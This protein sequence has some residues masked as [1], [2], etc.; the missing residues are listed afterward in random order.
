M[1][2]DLT[3]FGSLLLGTIVFAIFAPVLGCLLTGLDRKISAKMQGRIGPPI[4]QP[5]YDAMKLLSKET[6]SINSSERVYVWMSLIFAFLAGGIFLSGGNL[7]LCI[8]VITLSNLMFIMAGYC[9]RSPYADAGSAR[10]ILQVMAYEPAILIFAIC[11]IMALS[12]SGIEVVDTGNVSTLLTCSAPVIT[13][14]WAS[15]IG[16]VYVLTIK[17]RKSPFDLSTSHHAHQ[18]LVS[19]ITTEMTGRTLALVELTHWVESVL[20]L[21]WIGL[22][23]VFSNPLSIGLAILVALLVWFLEI[24]IDN[25]AARVKWQLML[26][27]A[28]I[29]AL[30]TGVVNMALLVFI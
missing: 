30:I 25:N 27:S 7:L 13:T 17:L 12:K 1:S 5:F 18:E 15:F 10:E 8:F 9:S 19:G 2:I 23:F 11:I 6:A 22:F 28:W 3:Y 4:M 21:A 29:V 20:F 24:V 14:C 26:K 16:L